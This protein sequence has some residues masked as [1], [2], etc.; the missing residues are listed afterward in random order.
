MKTIIVKDL[1]VPLEEYA[2]VSED[3]TLLEAVMALEAA[4]EKIDRE[5]YKYLHRAILVLNRSGK[6]V[7]KI[8]QGL[9]SVPPFSRSC[10]KNT[11]FGTAA[12]RIFAE[13]APGS[14]SRTSCIHPLRENTYGMTP[15]WPRPCICSSW[16]VTTLCWW[17]ET[18]TS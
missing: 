4:Q 10:S 12:W 1:M 8:S 2:T 6:V 18:R 13:S 7:G 3:A 9:V 15:H 17:F 11:P 5:K 14:R 16:G